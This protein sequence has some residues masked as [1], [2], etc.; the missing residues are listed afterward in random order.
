MRKDVIAYTL[1][2]AIEPSGFANAFNPSMHEIKSQVVTADPAQMAANIAGL[3]AGYGPALALSLALGLGLSFLAKSPVP[4]LATAASSAYM[5]HSYEM[6][7]PAGS[8]LG[9]PVAQLFNAPAAAPAI[10]PWSSAGR[11]WL[12]DPTQIL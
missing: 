8:R 9:D 1:I 4:L 2:A 3:R 5:I 12:A 10:Q 11:A 7:L 6:A